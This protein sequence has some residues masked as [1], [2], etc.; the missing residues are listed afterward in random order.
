M[1]FETI[2]MTWYITHDIERYV[3]FAN[4][5]VVHKAFQSFWSKI[6]T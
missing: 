1:R 2:A 4:V 5:E 3:D 6:L